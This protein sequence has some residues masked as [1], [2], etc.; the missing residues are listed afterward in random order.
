MSAAISRNSSR[1]FS[2]SSRLA[3]FARSPLLRVAPQYA[4]QLAG[5][6]RLAI[7]RFDSVHNVPATF[8]IPLLSPPPNA[9]LLVTVRGE[10]NHNPPPPAHAK[11]INQGSPKLVDRVFQPS[12]GKRKG[13]RGF[14]WSAWNQRDVSV[15]RLYYVR[16]AEE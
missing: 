14:C 3:R 1:V 12:L 4:A 10:E 2:S 5:L 6:A 13:E 16:R 7:N 15:G 11:K 8:A 9:L